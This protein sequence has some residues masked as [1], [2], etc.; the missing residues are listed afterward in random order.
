MM[1]AV[2]LAAETRES[3]M[4]VGALMP[5]TPAPDAPPTFLRDLTDELRGLIAPRYAY[6]AEYRFKYLIEPETLVGHF[7]GERRQF[8]EAIVQ[9]S[10]RART[11]CTVD[12]DALYRNYRAERSRVV[13]AL[14]WF[15]EKGWIELESKQ[16]TEVYSVLRRDFDAE[17]LS[18]PLASTL[19]AVSFRS[20]MASAPP[21][22]RCNEQTRSILPLRSRQSCRIRMIGTRS[23]VA[24]PK[25]RPQR[26]AG[27]RPALRVGVQD[28]FSGFRM[29]RDGSGRRAD[30]LDPLR[31]ISGSATR[32]PRA[33]PKPEAVADDA[34]PSG[35]CVGRS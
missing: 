7:D 10:A 15:Q 17:V 22:S 1:D 4:Q 21:P 19:L 5:F 25:R 23:R 27:T 28:D 32:R 14:D 18:G 12:F 24:P 26:T 9:T 30:T 6:F 8:V 31:G 11:W 13:K 16:M 29:N 34:F 33:L 3:M 2:F 35:S 20:S